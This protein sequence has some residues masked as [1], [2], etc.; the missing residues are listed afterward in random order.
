MR[1]VAMS[2]VVKRARA[3]ISAQNV[4]TCAATIMADLIRELERARGRACR[5][6]Q[7]LAVLDYKEGVP[8]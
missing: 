5:M 1:G 6:A 7:D 4:P 2:D 3:W 8:E